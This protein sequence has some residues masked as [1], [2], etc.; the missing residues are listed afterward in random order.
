MKEMK[1]PSTG[2]TLENTKQIELSQIRDVVRYEKVSESKL[3]F[4]SHWMLNDAIET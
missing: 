3:Q 2:E 1:S 4:A